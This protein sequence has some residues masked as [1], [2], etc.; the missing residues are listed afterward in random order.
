MTLNTVKIRAR[1]TI[2][3]F[4]VET[5]YILSFNV[6]KERN[7]KS[8]FTAALKIEEDDLNNLM[9]DV[10]TISAGENIPKLIFTG[11][12]LQSSPSPC[13]DDPKYVVLNI[14]GAD[15][16][17]MLDNER[18]TRLANYSE[19][20][21]A[22]ITGINRKAAKGTQFRLINSP[23]TMPTDGD[24]ISDWEK[25]N[26]LKSTLLDSNAPPTPG[27]GSNSVALVFKNLKS[28][29]GVVT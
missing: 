17:Y 18:F 6:S 29:S 23:V 25:S 16:L 20:S 15:V 12:I 26:I 8:T 2:G 10:V 28:S 24:N 22:I 11:Y 3:D 9:G 4:V 27:D 19:D 14:S 13:W 5:P 7:K 1:V 21:W